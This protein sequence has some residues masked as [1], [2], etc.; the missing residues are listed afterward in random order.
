MTDAASGAILE[1]AVVLQRIAAA[2][3]VLLGER[4]DSEADHAA[5]RWLLNA[6]HDQR[7]QAS[8]VLEMIASERQPRIE[9]VQRWLGQGKQVSQERLAEMLD[10]DQRWPWAV[11]GGLVSDAT[12]RGIA[13]QGGNLARREVDALLAMEAAVVFPQPG[14]RTRLADA[15]LGMHAGA[16]SMLEGMLAVQRAR[17]N[18]MA[19]VLANASTPTLLLA[20]RWH[21]LRGTGVPGYLGEDTPV[22]VIAPASPGETIDAADA[23]LVWWLG[24]E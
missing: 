18:R 22:L 20:G 21:V 17:D 13:L 2:P 4:H 1:E 9:R 19:L 6:L 14:A 5:Q 11:Y 3:R 8:I 7:P 12:G 10:W 15:V 16:E 23:D 24:D